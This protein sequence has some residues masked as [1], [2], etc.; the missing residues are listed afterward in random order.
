MGYEKRDIR[1]WVKWSDISLSLV[2]IH[3]DKYGSIYDHISS[4]LTTIIIGL[5]NHG[6]LRNSANAAKCK[7][8]HKVLLL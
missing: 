2:F 1:V 4:N 7:S 6:L 5:A 8:I 3:A